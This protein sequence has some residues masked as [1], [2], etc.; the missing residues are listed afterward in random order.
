MKKTQRT[1]IGITIFS[2][3][4]LVSWFCDYAPGIDIGDT[5][6]ENLQQ[7]LFVLPCVF[8]LIGLFDVWVKTETVERHLGEGSG[9]LSYMWSILL[10][11]TS[12]GGIHVALPVAHALY[13]KRARLSVILVYLGAAAICRIP[14]TLFEA[15]FL[16]WRFTAIRLL[17]SLPLVILGS[18]VLAWWIGRRGFSLPEIDQ[19]R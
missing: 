12:V 9:L 11:F 16:G 5:F 18:I 17:V 7:M 15:S 13:L 3:F 8:V 6:L 1:L 2:L 19:D 10:S 14:M 4:I